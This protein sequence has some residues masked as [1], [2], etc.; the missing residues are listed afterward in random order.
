MEIIQEDQNHLSFKRK[1][2][3]LKLRIGKPKDVKRAVV[4]S[5]KN[6]KRTIKGLVS[7]KTAPYRFI[8]HITKKGG[9]KN[10]RSFRT[11]D[12]ETGLKKTILSAGGGALKAGAAAATVL[13]GGA[14][15]PGLAAL[16]AGKGLAV[17]GASAYA[18]K[19]LSE[20]GK[21]SINSLNPSGLLDRAKEATKLAISER[22]DNDYPSF[23]EEEKKSYIN[24]YTKLMPLKAAMRVAVRERGLSPQNNIS[25]LTGQFYDSIV[26]GTKDASAYNRADSESLAKDVIIDAVLTYFIK[27][28]QKSDS[29]SDLSKSEQ[30]A[31]K[32]MEIFER[33]VNDAIDGKVRDEAGSFVVENKGIIIGVAVAMVLLVVVLIARK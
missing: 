3:K 6:P 31:A 9:L 2:G 8:N 18:L 33:N 15:S 5:V 4:N 7:V 22:I 27:A 23:K 28:K 25:G 16:T 10:I 26:S 17:K 19:K 14:A 20:R 13:T 29:G 30:V 12:R 32:G 1:G 24:P 11:L 21:K